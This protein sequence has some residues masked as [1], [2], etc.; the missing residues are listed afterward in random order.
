MLRQL[1]VSSVPFP[2]SFQALDVA[3]EVIVD[4]FINSCIVLISLVKKKKVQ[5]KTMRMFSAYAF[6]KRKT[7]RQTDRQT[8]SMKAVLIYLRLLLERLPRRS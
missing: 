2:E 4:N 5:D 3:G 6:D 8:V 1:T 7:G